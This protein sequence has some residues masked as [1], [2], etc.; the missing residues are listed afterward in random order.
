MEPKCILW[1]CGMMLVLMSR[2]TA[3]Q[4]HSLPITARQRGRLL[5]RTTTASAVQSSTSSP[6]IEAHW[7][8]FNRSYHSTSL[9]SAVEIPLYANSV[10]Y[11]LS[12]GLGNPPQTFNVQIDT[13]SSLFAVPMQGCKECSHGHNPY[14][15]TKSSSGT[16]ISCSDGNM[17]SKKQCY[18]G[19]AGS[20]LFNVT[21]GDHSNIKG[22]LI[23]DQATFQGISTD[24]SVKLVF[25][26]ILSELPNNGFQSSNVDGIFGLA[27]GSERMACLPNCVVPPFDVM[28]KYA[29][30][31]DIFSLRLG[32][33]HQHSLDG[34]MTF[35][36]VEP[37]QTSD[38]LYTP[39]LEETYYVVGFDDM[40]IGGVSIMTKR[41]H[42]GLTVVDSGTTFLILT[43]GVYASVKKTF[44][45]HYCHL[46]YICSDNNI[47]DHGK[48]LSSASVNISVIN[49]FPKVSLVLEGVKLTLDPSYYM[50]RIP[51]IHG[52]IY[53]LGMVDSGSD[54]ITILGDTFMKA[55]YIIF[56]RENKRIG[57]IGSKGTVEAVSEV[58]LVT[59]QWIYVVPVIAL[60]ALVVV[61]LFAVVIMWAIWRKNQQ[62]ILRGYSPLLQDIEQ[63]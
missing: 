8:S 15:P 44:Q 7:P 32:E 53:C 42:Y 30:I 63:E 45:A 39:I 17:C 31:R 36:G 51:T 41:A 40:E 2:T 10:E 59:P 34:V 21:Y 55:F 49:E 25:G 4:V 6:F 43:K 9:S 24:I 16:V 60:G 46:P 28:E 50:E 22:A 18:T 14:D 20:C 13:G 1:A 54:S 3:E 57:F 47:F 35:G 58:P 38:P 27:Y 26:G 19:L 48:C 5:M 37:N 52:D 12:I 23:Q 33:H 56:D 11:Y 29:G 62:P 61:A